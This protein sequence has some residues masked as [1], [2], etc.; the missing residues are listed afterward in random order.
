MLLSVNLSMSLSLSYMYTCIGVEKD[1][2]I[3][4]AKYT[5]KAKLDLL[6]SSLL[7]KAAGDHSREARKLR[8]E[9]NNM[10]VCMHV[11]T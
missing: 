4:A 6:Q 9:V 10:Y 7:K 8:E 5:G 11:V 2:A 3:R 1:L